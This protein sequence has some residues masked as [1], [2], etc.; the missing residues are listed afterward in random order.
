M[1]DIKTMYAYSL[2]LANNSSTLVQSFL[3]SI[4]VPFI[5]VLLIEFTTFK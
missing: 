5:F 1:L 4:F 3:F 2:C